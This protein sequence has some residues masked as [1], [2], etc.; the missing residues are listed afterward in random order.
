MVS[1]N[2]HREEEDLEEKEDDDDIKK[3]PI[4]RKNSHGRKTCARTIRGNT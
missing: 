2:A 4:R 3:K 1:F